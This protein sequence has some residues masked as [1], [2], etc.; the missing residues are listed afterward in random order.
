MP[1]IEIKKLGSGDQSWLGSTHG[2]R[3]AQTMAFDPENFT[4]KVVNGVIPS[5]TPLAIHEKKL[6]PYDTSGGSTKDVLVGFLLTDQPKSGG[7]RGVAVLDHG[8]VKVANLPDKQ[9]SPPEAGK[10]KTTIV[11]IAKEA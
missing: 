5:G 2:L 3:A 10:D 6:V 11:F 1:G 8:R 7:A 4:D 9:F